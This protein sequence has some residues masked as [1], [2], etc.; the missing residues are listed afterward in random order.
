MGGGLDLKPFNFDLHKAP[1]VLKSGEYSFASDVYAFSI[2]MWAV[3]FRSKPF[4]GL[5]VNQIAT[6][7][8]LGTRPSLDE[9]TCPPSLKELMA[10]YWQADAQK[11]S[12]MREVVEALST[13]KQRIESGKTPGDACEVGPVRVPVRQLR[14]NCG[15]SY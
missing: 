14:I 15:L 7:V 10:R 6:V 9:A 1:E 3:A 12:T 13:L 4:F 8:Q 2:L 5:S 11:R